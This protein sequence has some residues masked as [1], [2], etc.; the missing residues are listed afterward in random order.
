FTENGG[1]ITVETD[2]RDGFI[3]LRISDTGIGMSPETLQHIFRPFEQGPSEMARQYGGLGLG[4][5]IAKALVDAQGGSITARSEGLGKGSTFIA[6]IPTAEGFLPNEVPQVAPPASAPSRCLRLLLVEDHSDS[7]HALG[8][9]LQNL[10][11]RVTIAP[12][13]GEALR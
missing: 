4:L 12:T 13:V 7:A 8:R 1:R 3:E 9:I 2:N 6:S 10:G 11:H 5:A